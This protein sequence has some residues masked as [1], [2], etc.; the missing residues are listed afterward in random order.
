MFLYGI[1]G[2]GGRRRRFWAVTSFE[3]KDGDAIR[4]LT[5]EGYRQ[6]R[7]RGYGPGLGGV[8]KWEIVAW[9]LRVGELWVADGVC[10]I[11]Y[12]TLMTVSSDL[13]LNA[14]PCSGFWVCCNDTSE[15][16]LKE[17][18]LLLRSSR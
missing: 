2:P 5:V 8:C 1:W 15:V 18:H 10:E 13:R 9:R 7:E 3:G 14:I 17:I 11:P 16:S 6:G 4:G 12:R